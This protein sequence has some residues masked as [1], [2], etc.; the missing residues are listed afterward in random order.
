MKDLY[1]RLGLPTNGKIDPA[2]VRARVL[3]LPDEQLRRDCERVLLDPQARA[4]YD[5]NLEL[6][7]KIAVARAGLGISSTEH[8]GQAMRA[9]FPV[10]ATAP[11]RRTAATGGPATAAGGE[12]KYGLAI[13]AVVAAAVVFGLFA[14]N[15]YLQSPPYHFR[16]AE[17]ANTAAAYKAFVD[18]HPGSPEVEVARKRM[19]EIELKGIW[20]K[21]TESDKHALKRMDPASASQLS[22]IGNLSRVADGIP[23]TSAGLNAARLLAETRSSFIGQIDSGDKLDFFVKAFPREK[24]DEALADP[25]QRHIGEM[26]DKNVIETVLERLEKAR[27]SRHGVAAEKIRELEKKARDRLVDLFFAEAKRNETPAALE[28]F[29]AEN[30]TS[31]RIAEAL[32]ILNE[33]KRRYADFAFVRKLD[34]KEAYERFLE[35]KQSGSEADAAR[36]RLVDLEVDE[37]L[38]GDVGELPELQPLGYTRNSTKASIEVENNTSHTLTVRYS[39]RDSQKHDLAPREKKTFTLEKGEYRV[40][41]TVNAAQVRPYA[42]SE[43]VNFDLYA[44]TFYISS[45]LSPSFPSF[46]PPIYRS[47]SP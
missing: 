4:V 37:I 43:S 40:T 29:I 7:R 41:A 10:A 36:K 1:K 9:E 42:G 32:E 33:L 2:T 28:S 39:G 21:V 14:F 22:L 3:R 34:T 23:E 11:G 46:N 25:L 16:K 13:S 38:K 20:K 47:K 6:L 35:Y 5:R 26:M 17:K 15:A 12:Q 45:S 27:K 24:I 18:A 30:R 19:V 44:V 31:D 8:W